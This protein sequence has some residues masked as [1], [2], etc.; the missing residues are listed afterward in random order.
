VIDVQIY[1]SFVSSIQ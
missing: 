1:V